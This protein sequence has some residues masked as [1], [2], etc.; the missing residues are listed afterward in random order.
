[1]LDCE[2]TDELY[3]DSIAFV[4]FLWGGNK[5]LSGKVFLNYIPESKL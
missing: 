4:K 5:Q 1:M 2:W 3:A